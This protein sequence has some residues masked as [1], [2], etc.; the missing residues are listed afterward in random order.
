MSSLNDRPKGERSWLLAKDASGKEMYLITSTPS[1]DMY[2]LYVPTPEG[3]K[4]KYKHPSAGQVEK[5]YFKGQK[6]SGS[7]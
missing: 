6:R 7:S 5:L 4:R 1:R 2:F 3:W